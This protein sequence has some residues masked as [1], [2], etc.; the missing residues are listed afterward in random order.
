[1]FGVVEMDRAFGEGV[2]TV[3]PECSGPFRA[4][5][6]SRPPSRALAVDRAD[7]AVELVASASSGGRNGGRVTQ[8]RA[9]FLNFLQLR[10]T[11][12]NFEP[13]GRRRLLARE[14][15]FEESGCPSPPW[16]AT[17]RASSGHRSLRLCRS[18]RPPGRGPAERFPS[19]P[20]TRQMFRK[21]VR[22]EALG[23]C[24]DNGRP[25]GSQHQQDF[26]K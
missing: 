18:S 26:D 24:A 2:D 14:I 1:M 19:C 16:P 8:T 20:F 4:A 21:S 7:A 15:Q 5:K 25:A 6:V 9:T 12:L 11:S 13:F 17:G 10:Q 3:R 23:A 22:A